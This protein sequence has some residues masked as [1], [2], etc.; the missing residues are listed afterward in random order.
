MEVSVGD[1]HHYSQEKQLCG[2]ILP[3]LN[4]QEDLKNVKSKYRPQ[5]LN[6][7]FFSKEV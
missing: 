3:V 6:F 7:F 5:D 1:P 2:A 4:F